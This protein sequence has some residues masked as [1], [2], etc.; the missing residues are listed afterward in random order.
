MLSR[1]LSVAVVFGLGSGVAGVSHAQV[2]GCTALTETG[3]VPTPGID[4]QVAAWDGWVAV[5]GS[6][7]GSIHLVDARDAEDPVLRSSV[8]VTGAIYELAIGD[9]VIAASVNDNGPSYGDLLIYEWSN[10]NN[11]RLA[12]R[13]ES[14]PLEGYIALT[15]LGDLLY[16][17]DSD[18]ITIFDISNPSLPLWVT[19]FPMAWVTDIQF[20]DGYAYTTQSGGG[21][22][23]FTILDV[24]SPFN[25][26]EKSHLSFPFASVV[27]K[28]SLGDHFAAV[29]VDLFTVYAIDVQNPSNP[30]IASTVTSPQSIVSTAARFNALYIGEANTGGLHVYDLSEPASPQWIASH[31]PP[32]EPWDVAVMQGVVAVA[33]RQ[34]GVRLF[35]MS[36]CSGC[37]P[38]LA[39]PAGVLDF[40]DV[41]AFLSAF[42]TEGRAADLD[43]NAVW[44]VRD[45]LLYLEAFAEGCP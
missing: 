4:T 29:T 14:T 7:N 35:Q 2:G 27:W 11:V 13:I 32:I 37:R 8:A 5:S 45:V 23:G 31:N 21:R 26:V 16:A 33:D 43:V 18:S 24:S 28:V 3:L 22:M 39:E 44:D 19:S 34:S 36:D 15:F 25:V 20:K 41:Q 17:S 40:Y 30:A 38:D 1:N 12:A 10:P 6:T 42:M 9:G